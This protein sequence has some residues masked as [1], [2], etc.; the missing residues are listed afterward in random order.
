MSDLWLE[1]VRFQ[2]AGFLPGAL[3]RWLLRRGVAATRSAEI[4]RVEHAFQPQPVL[5]HPPRLA[6]PPVVEQFRPLRRVGVEGAR[7]EPQPRWTPRLNP[8]QVPPPTR[9]QRLR[10]L[11][12]P[13]RGP[14]AYGEIVLPQPLYPFQG[15][16]VQFLAESDGAVLAD[17]MGLGKTIQT[18]V[19]LRVLVLRG[20]AQD[21]L[22][23]CPKAV[24]FNWCR[25]LSRWAPDLYIVPISGAGRQPAWRSHLGASHVIVTTYESA[26]LDID[27]FRAHA[28]GVVVADE[29][30]RLKNPSTKTAQAIQRIQAGRRWGL[31]G[32]PLENELA[33]VAGVYGFARP[34]LLRGLAAPRQRGGP[35]LSVDERLAADHARSQAVRERIRPYL[36]RRRKQ[37]VKELG[38]PGK[39]TGDILLDLD[40]AQRRAYDRAERDGVVRLQQSQTVSIDSVLALITRLKQ[41]CNRDPHSGESAKLAFLREEY[42]AEALGDGGKVLIFSQYVET[43]AWL[44][45]ELQAYAPLLYSGNLSERARERA[46][47]QFQNDDEHRLLLVS[48]RAGGMGLNLT[49]ANYVVHFDHW[50]NPAVARQA[51]DRAY[52]IGQQRTVFVHRLLS[53]ETIEERIARQLA[54]KQGLFDETIDELADSA[55]RRSLS[56]EELY[57]LFGLRPPTA[58]RPA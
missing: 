9:L 7:F 43:L 55:L 39:V 19:A 20:Q 50:W 35:R 1:A 45:D 51:E 52:R 44:R 46:V 4:V 41:I 6:P 37:D 33:D 23:L 29:A 40:E 22:V 58:G 32:T 30:H 5:S 2:A 3:S 12:S 14:H 24:V 27:L 16:G 21:A 15:G 17:D 31:T 38:L 10:P 42:L 26:R 49:R 54:A 56:A 53:V 28:F 8:A 13:R 11:L 47:D 48:L 36:L 34:G 25:E 18:I 57:G